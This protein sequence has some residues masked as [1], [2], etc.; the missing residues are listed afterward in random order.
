ML[1]VI[2]VWV[3]GALLMLAPPVAVIIAGLTLCAACGML[4]QAYRP[5]MWR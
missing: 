4:C 5:A 1:G 3:A 2:A